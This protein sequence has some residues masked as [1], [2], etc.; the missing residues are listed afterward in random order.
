M[1]VTLVVPKEYGLVAA[2]GL[3]TATFLAGVRLPVAVFRVTHT[4]RSTIL[5]SVTATDR[6]QRFN[7]HNVRIEVPG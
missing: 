6:K 1:S 4:V 2:V 3:S 7:I 5:L